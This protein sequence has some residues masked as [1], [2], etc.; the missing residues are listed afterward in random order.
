MPA[1][2][3]AGFLRAVT[4]DG[5]ISLAARNAV[6]PWLYGLGAA[7][8]LG[9]TTLVSAGWSNL[10]AGVPI[11]AADHAAIVAHAQAHAVPGIS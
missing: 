7:L 1:P 6:A 8:Q 10:V 3:P 9:D 4:M 5:S 2:D 11:S